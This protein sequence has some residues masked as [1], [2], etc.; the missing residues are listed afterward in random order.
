MQRKKTNSIVLQNG[1]ITRYTKGKPQKAG[2]QKLADSLQQRHEKLANKA[3]NNFYVK[4]LAGR[5]KED[6]TEEEL[7]ELFQEVGKLEQENFEKIQKI[8]SLVHKLPLFF[9]NNDTRAG[10]VV[11]K[12][13]PSSEGPIEGHSEVEMEE[14]DEEEEPALTQEDMEKF[15]ALKREFDQWK[16]GEKEKEKELEEPFTR[17]S[18][19]ELDDLEKALRELDKEEKAETAERLRKSEEKG[20]GLVKD[21]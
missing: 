20:K 10:T 11:P 3:P 13:E 14:R 6:L 8:Q 2:T 1:N 19:E 21:E 18:E 15:D 12:K 9:A 4:A 7:G 16:A 17:V 5:K